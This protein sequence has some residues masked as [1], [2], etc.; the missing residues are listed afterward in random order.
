MIFLTVNDTPSGVFKS[1]VVDVVIF[2]NDISK[3]EI[4]LVSFISFRN[5][6]ANRHTI[7]SWY[8]NSTVIPMVPG[9]HNWKKNL[10]S[11]RFIKKIKRDKIIARGVMAFDLASKLNEKVIYDGRGAIKAELQEFPDMIPNKMVVEEL[12]AA[13]A[14]AVSNAFF[15]IAVSNKLVDY[16]KTEYGYSG[17]NHVVI[18]CTFST[19]HTNGI[20]TKGDLRKE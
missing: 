3:Q 7:K 13:E 17:S 14:N 6:W 2:L 19:A 5:Y 16:W 4:K 11:L 8:K 9:I 1:Q 18:P 20:D 10:V 15:K 12:I